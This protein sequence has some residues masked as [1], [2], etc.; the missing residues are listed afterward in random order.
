[1][2]TK[3]QKYN[4]AKWLEEW[5]NHDTRRVMPEGKV[6]QKQ[7]SIANNPCE[8]GQVRAIGEGR[9]LILKKEKD[10]VLI[11]QISEFNNPAAESEIRLNLSKLVLQIW[12]SFR[13]P[14]AVLKEYPVEDKI[15]ESDLKEANDFWTAYFS[16][17][18]YATDQTGEGSI[19]DTDERVKY[20]DHS[21]SKISDLIIKAFS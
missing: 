4:S 15:L 2:T 1:M 17:K 10:N 13:V 8:A 12:N 3:W 9:V 19:Y 14:D 5:H 6:G 7:I 21:V 18:P 11:C 20:M 16:M